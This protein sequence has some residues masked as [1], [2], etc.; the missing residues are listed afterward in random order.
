MQLI[1]IYKGI[2]TIGHL[3]TIICTPDLILTIYNLHSF[4]MFCL[5]SNSFLPSP[6]ALKRVVKGVSSPLAFTL[7]GRISFKVR[8]LNA[9]ILE[10]ILT[11]PDITN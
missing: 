10:F 8:R 7:R 11:Q 3:L 1:P 2:F 9:I 4:G 6:L 5:F